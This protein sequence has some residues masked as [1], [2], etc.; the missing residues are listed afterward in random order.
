MFEKQRHKAFNRAVLVSWFLPY[1][2]IHNV[3][4]FRFSQ[5][6]IFSMKHYHRLRLSLQDRKNLLTLQWKTNSVYQPETKLCVH[7]CTICILLLFRR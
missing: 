2:N 4:Q 6:W 5:P 7:V 1:V 3:K